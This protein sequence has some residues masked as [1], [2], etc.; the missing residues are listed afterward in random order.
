MLGNPFSPKKRATDMPQIAKMAD[1]SQYI[2]EYKG[3][4]SF[5]V[6]LDDAERYA[7]SLVPQFKKGRVKTVAPGSAWDK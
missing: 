7:K 6:N 5:F 2:V 4:H 3:Q 1:S